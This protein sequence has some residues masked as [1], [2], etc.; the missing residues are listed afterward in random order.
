MSVQRVRER[1]GVGE[2]EALRESEKRRRY[3]QTYCRL[4]AP[5]RPSVRLST[6]IHTAV[7]DTTAEESAPEIGIATRP[8]D[9][10]VTDFRRRVYDLVVQEALVVH[11]L[12]HLLYSD[13]ADYHTR[14]EAVAADR[15]RLFARVWNLLEDGAVERQLRHRYAVGTELDVLN[16][17]L[18]ADA[19]FGHRATSTAVRR[20]GLFDAVRCGLADM[21]VYDSGRFRRLL[22][23]TDDSV[24]MASAHD[25]RRLRAFVPTMRA[26]VADVVGEPAP[27]ARNERIVSFWNELAD[28]LDDTGWSASR[29]TELDRLLDADG[30]IT[31][32]EGESDGRRRTTDA[33]VLEADGSEAPIAG[34]PDDTAARSDRTANRAEE[35]DRTAVREEITRQA[36]TAT[37]E[38]DETRTGSNARQ[39]T[40]QDSTTGGEPDDTATGAEA[41]SAGTDSA[42]DADSASPSQAASTNGDASGSAGTQAGGTDAPAGETGALDRPAVREQYERELAAEIEAMDDGTARMAELQAYLDAIHEASDG[43]D[44][45]PELD[46][47]E[48]PDTTG[49]RERWAV[50]KQSSTRL[51][52]RFRSRLREQRRDTDRPRSRRGTLD[53]GRL[54]AAAR[55]RTDV[56]IDTQEGD[57]KAYDC[58]LLLDRSASMSDGSVRAAETAVATV[59][60]ALEAVGVSVTVLDLHESTVRLVSAAPESLREARHSLTAGHAAGGTP[61][62]M[63]LRLLRTRF[64]DIDNPFALVVTDGRPDDRER[65]LAELDATTFPVLGVYL[66]DADSVADGAHDGDEAYFHGHALVTDWTRLDRRLHTLA[67]QVLF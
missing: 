7:T 45:S 19:S 67:E 10:P 5:V 9:Q 2:A 55:G 12:G 14:L 16:A 65:Y 8:F 62:A 28:V 60:L 35:L 4:L 50:A 1:L 21:A 38:P 54:V 25:E 3:L 27:G 51:A 53:R 59:A 61:L 58:V 32:A 37:G 18:L 17:N 42:A 47:V 11:E 20:F 24:R 43:I 64:Q 13:I 22:D 34:K 44:A 39:A 56:F 48:D 29:A 57:Q 66:T 46:V 6:D 52:R 23:G 36:R 33:T 30:S 41:V 63:A 40:G 49:D 26:A 15:R 31:T